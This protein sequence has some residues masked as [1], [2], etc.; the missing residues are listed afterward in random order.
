MATAEA[1]AAEAMAVAARVVARVAG[2]RA[3]AVTEVGKAAEAMAVEARAVARAAA[4]RAAA[5]RVVVRAAAVKAEVVT[6]VGRVEGGG[7]A[8]GGRAAAVRDEAIESMSK[9][10]Q[11]N[12]HFGT[13]ETPTVSR[14][15]VGKKQCNCHFDGVDQ[16]QHG[17]PDRETTS[18]PAICYIVTAWC[19]SASISGPEVAASTV[20][21]APSSRSVDFRVR[22]CWR[23]FYM[24]V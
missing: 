4:A 14:R 23:F 17:A 16:A 10:L 18:S 5:A 24:S 7:A 1:T 3:A 20:A 13:L 9:L 19:D 22:C 11:K 6:A 8:R 21:L 2:A 12:L 15:A